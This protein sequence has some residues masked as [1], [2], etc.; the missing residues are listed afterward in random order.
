MKILIV[1]TSSFGDVIH[2]FPVV[3]YLKSKFPDA[4]IDWVV[5]EP[6]RQVLEAHPDINRVLPIVTKD[7]RKGENSLAFWQ[8][9]RDLHHVEYDLVLDLQG[10]IKSGFFTWLSRGKDK[11]GFAYPAVPEWPN[12]F[13]TKK[14]FLPPKGQN[15][16][17]DYLSIVQ[18]YF[19]DA[20]TYEDKG[21]SLEIS[22]DQIQIVG[23]I[24]QNAQLQQGKKVL[25]CP[26]SAWENKQLPSETLVEV[27]KKMP[28]SSFLFLW[29]TQ[30]EKDAADKLQ[31]EF[32]SNSLVL[33]RMELPTLQNLM[34]SVDLIVSMDSL[35]LHLAATTS[36][37]TLSFF[38]PSNADKYRPKGEQHRAIQGS[39]PYGK[40][41]EKR[42]PILRTCATG[43][44]IRSI[45][46][47]S[48]ILT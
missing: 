17:D 18:Q 34:A 48:E 45:S 12:L 1:K 13:F 10:N 46:P 30:K 36:T 15:I 35:P 25:V 6:I 14:R 5:E 38:G 33:D 3:G 22:E 26:G 44:C 43:A 2:T 29:G 19:N 23:E 40:T 39:C 47:E 24:L 7:W 11:I 9:R 4:Q 41:F 16:R 8:F 27:L 37:P 31:R 21:V 20:E 28:E 42:C 32:P